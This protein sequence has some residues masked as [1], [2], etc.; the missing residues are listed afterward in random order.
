MKRVATLLFAALLLNSSASALADIRERAST[1]ADQ[2]SVNLTVYNDGSALIHDRR[3]ITI[4]TGVNRIAW[5]D[6]SASMDPTSAVLDAMGSGARPSVLEQNF[7]YD[8]LGQDSLLKSYVGRDVVIVHPARFAGETSR[9]ERARILSVENGTVLQYADRIETAL[10]GYIE[11]PGVPKNLR[12]RPTLTL[13]IL[14]PRGSSQVLDLQYLTSGITWNVDYV[15]TLSP[16]ESH[17]TLT[18]MVTLA[19]TSGTSYQNA[20]LQLVAGSI[21]VAAT[22]APVKM[23]ATI[24]SG[25]GSDVYNANASQEQLFQ[26]HLYTL[27][28]STNI[29]DKQTKQLALLTAHDI[30]VTRALELRGEPYYYQSQYGDLGSRLPV[31]VHV[32]FEN[33]GGELGIPL[34]AGAMRIYQNDSRGLAQFVGSDNIR[35]TPRKDTVRLYLGDCRATSSYEIEILNGKDSAQEVT[36]VEPVPGDWMIT[37]ESQTHKKSSSTTATWLVNVPADGKASLT[38]TTDVSWCR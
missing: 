30:P 32:S 10:D 20:R 25:V 11:F 4:N 38:Y 22:P 26:F 12:D 13:D 3:R 23:I 9:R 27:P 17:M 19:N 28:R 21:H 5:R 37:S 36:V 6:V 1:N 2:Q 8:V 33:R 18:G 34:P 7:N 35:H 16:D 14:A 24:R 29:L 15:G 31:S